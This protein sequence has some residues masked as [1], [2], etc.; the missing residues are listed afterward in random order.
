MEKGGKR[1]EKTP[2]GG[3]GGVGRGGAVG[4]EEEM[5]GARVSSEG[6]SGVG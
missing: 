1:K 4:G 3:G 2:W 5:W 6:W